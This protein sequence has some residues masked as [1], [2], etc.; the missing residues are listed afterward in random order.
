MGIDPGIRRVNPTGVAILDDR[1]NVLLTTTVKPHSD[2]G[3]W[4]TRVPDIG[5]TLMEIAREWHVGIG[6][7]AFEAPIISTDARFNPESTAPLWALIGMVL[8]MARTLAVPVVRVQP[9]EV[10][11]ALAGKRNA[12]KEDMQAVAKLLTGREM[13]SHEADAIGIVKA[14]VVKW[15]AMKIVAKIEMEERK[16]KEKAARINRGGVPFAEDVYL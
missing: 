1:D 15:H 12:T 6:L 4:L 3:E 14:G 5:D 9:T 8:G 10:K 7:I 16:V 13:S 11:L 2:K